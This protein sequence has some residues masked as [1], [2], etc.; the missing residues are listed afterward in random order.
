MSERT[1]ASAGLP[2][3]IV[4]PEPGCSASLA[5]ARAMDLAAHAFPLM[6]AAPIGWKAP[7]ANGYDVLL[8]GSANVFRHGGAGLTGLTGV[9]VH[10]VGETTASAAR[11]AGFTV[12]VTGSS[13]LQPLLSVLLP[14]TRVLRLAGAE[15]VALT[16]PTGVI[17]DERIVYAVRPMPLPDA[18]VLLLRAPAVIALHS[19]E[20]ARHLLAEFDRRRLPR[21]NHALVTIGP[22]VTAAA[23]G[24]WRT[25]LTADTPN[26]VA[27]L[28]K[29][30]NL[31]HTTDKTSRRN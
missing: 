23:G 25:V 9:P 21:S 4:R 7:D 14:G 12:A 2:L 13:G 11:S 16:V 6:A 29:A 30:R 17:M 8:A 3:V 28:A 31:C 1:A 18:L 19:A 27:L 20:A 24:G 26:D 22:R 5:R 15:R 10:A